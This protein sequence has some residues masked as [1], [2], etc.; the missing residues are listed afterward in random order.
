MKQTVTAETICLIIIGIATV[1]ILYGC[2][3]EFKK[4]R[5]QKAEAKANDELEWIEALV[6]EYEKGM[7][8]YRERLEWPIHNFETEHKHSAAFAKRLENVRRILSNAPHDE[9]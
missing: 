4:Y 7:I 2:W 3:R 9:P 6:R 5:E 1:L 8:D